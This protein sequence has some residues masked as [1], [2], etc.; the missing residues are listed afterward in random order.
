MPEYFS[1]RF[2]P[3]GVGVLSG[4]LNRRMDAGRDEYPVP[5]R[6]DHDARGIGRLH[7]PVYDGKALYLSLRRG[8]RSNGGGHQYAR[9]IFLTAYD[10]ALTYP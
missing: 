1:Q 5:V 9:L 8:L 7:D 10:H 6:A 3:I 2:V 4:S